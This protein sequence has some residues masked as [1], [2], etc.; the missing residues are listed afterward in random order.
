[1]TNNYNQNM[2]KSLAGGPAEASCMHAKQQHS[3]NISFG[4]IK[5]RW[6]GNWSHLIRKI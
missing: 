5:V 1:M 2:A 4:D 6:A 3:N